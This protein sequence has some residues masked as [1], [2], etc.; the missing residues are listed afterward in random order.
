[1][2]DWVTIETDVATV[3]VDLEVDGGPLL[4]TVS[5]RTARDRK[6]LLTAIQR[7]L[8]PAAYVLMAGRNSSD[9]SSGQAG[10]PSLSVV[11]ATQS[12]RSDSEARIGESGSG[13]MWLIT[14]QVSSALQDLEL[15][16]TWRLLLIDERLVGGQEG[17]IV[18][19]Q[20][21][22]VRRP[23][24]LTTPTFGGVALAGSSSRVCVELGELRRASGLFSFPGVGGVF[25]RHLGVRER[26]IFWR[27][28]LRGA[29][30]SALNTI[31]T[32]IEDEI[33]DGEDKTMVDAWS[34]SHESCVLKAFRRRGPRQRNALSGQVFQEF[35]LEFT[36]LG[37]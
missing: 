30:D 3:L 23:A 29:N 4:A 31:E 36:Q 24:E 15:E 6:V 22:E 10:M 14:E 5:A 9:K 34:R 32:A 1:M 26:P 17:L 7:E 8:L 13:G 18:W 11:I 35:E 19:E 33:R 20:R 27:G 25:D 16:S 2:S 28:Q 12:L 37:G 21:Y